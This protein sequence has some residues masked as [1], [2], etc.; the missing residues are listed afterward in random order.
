[1]SSFRAFR[2]MAENEVRASV[3]NRTALIFTLGLAVLFMIIFG[4]LF[5]GS[6]SRGELRRRQQRRHRGVRR[7][8]RRR[9]AAS[10]A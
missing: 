1:M 3:R 5:G 9:W 8:P 2:A 4:L 7:L 10:A 6:G